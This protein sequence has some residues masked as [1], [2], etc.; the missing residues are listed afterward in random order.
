M[1]PK[2]SQNLDQLE[3][4]KGKWVGLVD[5]YEERMKKQNKENDKLALSAATG[6]DDPNKTEKASVEAL[7]HY[8]VENNQNQSSTSLNDSGSIPFKQITGTPFPG[9][10]NAQLDVI[11]EED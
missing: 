7:K 1:I 9:V 4:N 11:G 5:E 10:S 8:S 6:V 3:V 2:L